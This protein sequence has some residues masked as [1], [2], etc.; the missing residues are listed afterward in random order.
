MKIQTRI[1]LFILLCIP[2]RILLAYFSLILN[3]Y[4]HLFKYFYFILIL[5]IGI[6]FLYLYFTNTRLNA[7][8]GGGTTWWKS[9]RIIH[10]I[11]YILASILFFLKYNKLS[12]YLLLLDTLYGFVLFVTKHISGII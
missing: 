10:G 9:F 7:L 5:S 1:I 3:K 4:N 12:F 2:S 11:N 8:E 6:S